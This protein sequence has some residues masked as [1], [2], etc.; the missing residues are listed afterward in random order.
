MDAISYCKDTLK[1]PLS[2]EIEHMPFRLISNAVL[3]ENGPK[4]DKPTFYK[5]RIGKDK[6]DSVEKAINKWAEEKGIP[7]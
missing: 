4:V 7:M 5:G 2:F 1:L 6:F 3:P